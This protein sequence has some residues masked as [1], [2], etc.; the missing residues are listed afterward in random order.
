[1]MYIFRVF[2]PIFVIIIQTYTLEQPYNNYKIR[3]NV[4][5]NSI[6]CRNS[7]DHFQNNSKYTSRQHCHKIKRKCTFTM[8]SLEIVLHFFH[9]SKLPSKTDTKITELEK[10][11]VYEAHFGV[12]RRFTSPT[13]SPPNSIR[14]KPL[15]QFTFNR[16]H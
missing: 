13:P 3:T 1:M 15:S 2:L 5:L 10:T 9:S 14:L 8:Y 11:S 16:P 4:I 7:K 12:G 6:L